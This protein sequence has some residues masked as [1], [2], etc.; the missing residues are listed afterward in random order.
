MYV[1]PADTPPIAN[2]SASANTM[3]PPPELNV[4]S[5][6][7]VNVVDA[8]SNA[9]SV[10]AIETVVELMSRIVPPSV[11][12]PSVVRAPIPVIS[13]VAEIFQSFESIAIA[14]PLSPRLIAPF[15][16][17]VPLAVIVPEAVI[18]AAVSVPVSVGDAENTRF[19][20]VPV[21]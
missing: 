3:S 15:A 13:P 6:V 12:V 20:Q 14:S 11:T 8:P 19:P 9:I 7:V 10:S 1:S 21:S 2:V 4:R 16:S 5:P 17:N 18:A